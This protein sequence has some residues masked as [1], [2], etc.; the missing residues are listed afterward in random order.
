MRPVSAAF[1]SALRG[2]H[3]MVADARVLTTYQEGVDPIGTFIPIINGDVSYDATADIRSSVSLTTDGTDMWSVQPNSL[4]TPY[5]NELFVRRGVDFGNG[6]VEWVSQGYFR[7]WSVDQPKEVDEPITITAYDRMSGIVDAKLVEPIQF[8]PGDVIGDIVS[9]LVGNVYL[10]VTIE[11]DDDTEFQTLDRSLIAE[12]ERYEFLNDLI[13]SYGK[14]MYFDYR[15]VLVI[16][17]PPDPDVPVYRVNSGAYGVLI[18]SDRSISREG[19]YNGV[20]VEGEGAD[21]LPPVRAIVTDDNPLSPTYWAGP[22]G[23]VPRFFTS[24][25]ITT[26]DQAIRAGVSILQQARGLPYNVDFATI[27]NA[28]LEPLDAVEIVTEEGDELH[29][30]ETLVVP[31]V[32]D[33]AMTA[34]TREQVLFLNPSS[35]GVAVV[36]H[37]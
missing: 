8:L 30:I 6:S 32:P 19:V 23:Q 33:V 29:V 2:S 9:L 36:S 12:K 15:G 5:G 22:F 27:V 3:R 26:E 11:W 25:F 24:N 31:L 17:F 10:D 14:I 20:V 37:E 13:T 28:A 1:L 18:S 7:I 16:K 4:L 34:T 35:G 21:S